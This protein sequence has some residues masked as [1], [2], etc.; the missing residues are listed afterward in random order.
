[1]FRPHALPAQ[2]LY[3]AHLAPALSECSRD[4]QSRQE[5][6]QS[7]NVE[8]LDRVMKQRREIGALLQGL[9][10]VVADLDSS[11]G[12]LQSQEAMAAS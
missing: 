9:E 5:A 7:E 11:V 4:L 10:S 1:M 8:M 2:Q 6:L 12:S 3:L